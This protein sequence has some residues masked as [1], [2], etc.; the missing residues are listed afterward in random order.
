MLNILKNL[1]CESLQVFIDKKVIK[2]N[3]NLTKLSQKVQNKIIRNY[4]ET[5]VTTFCRNVFSTK[6]LERDQKAKS[7]CQIGL[8]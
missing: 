1:V 7:L 4:T 6:N 5:Q 3:Y 2:Q 8:K